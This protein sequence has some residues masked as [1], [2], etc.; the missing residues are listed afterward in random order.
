MSLW[1]NLY[2]LQFYNCIAYQAEGVK[3]T[4]ESDGKV[5]VSYLKLNTYNCEHIRI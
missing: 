2:Q 3:T 5:P 4:F 1:D